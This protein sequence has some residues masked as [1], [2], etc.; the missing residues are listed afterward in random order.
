M[1]EYQKNF[2]NAKNTWLEISNKVREILNKPSTKFIIKI[3]MDKELNYYC[4]MHERVKT[5]RLKK[6]YLKKND[7]IKSEIKKNLK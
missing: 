3:A 4:Y 6:K 2:K 1:E 5:K 7:I